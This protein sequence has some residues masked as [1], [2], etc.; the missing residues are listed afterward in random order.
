MVHEMPELTA[1]SLVSENTVGF[2]STRPHLNDDDW[3]I[4]KYSSKCQ[5][6]GV[7]ACVCD[8][9]KRAITTSFAGGT[10]SLASTC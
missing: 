9:R 10:F 1:E 2:T 7:C 8:S 5:D 3:M 4:G 6:L